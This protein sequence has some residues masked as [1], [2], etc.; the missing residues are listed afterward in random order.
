M[1]NVHRTF[2]LWLI[3][4]TNLTNFKNTEIREK[5]KLDLP[6][7]H[8]G[9]IASKGCVVGFTVSNLESPASIFRCLS[10]IVYQKASGSVWLS[11]VVELIP[12]PLRSRLW[13]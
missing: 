7:S 8:P 1:L 11:A 13:R 2:G 4:L 5:L 9:P 6:S 12:N 10:Q 3:Y